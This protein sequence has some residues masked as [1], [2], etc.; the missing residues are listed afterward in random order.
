M[1]FGKK[2]AFCVLVARLAVMQTTSSRFESR[3]RRHHGQEKAVC[4]FVI[5]FIFCVHG[6]S[7][8]MWVVRRKQWHQRERQ[9]SE[10]G[11]HTA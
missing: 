5:F 1:F 7:M 10:R 3:E 8:A 4:T 2:S 11:R 6:A 9:R